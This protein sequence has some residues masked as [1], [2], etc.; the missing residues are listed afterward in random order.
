MRLLD[1]H[2]AIFVVGMGQKSFWDLSIGARSYCFQSIALFSL[3]HVVLSLEW[4]WVGGWW[5]DWLVGSG[6]E[7]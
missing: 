6:S 1:V 5:L 4:W 7:R 3:F 2:R